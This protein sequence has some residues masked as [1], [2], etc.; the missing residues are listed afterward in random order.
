MAWIFDYDITCWSL[1]AIYRVCAHHRVSIGCPC[2]LKSKKLKFVSPHVQFNNILHFCFLFFGH[3]GL[4]FR[5]WHYILSQYPLLDPHGDADAD[6]IHFWMIWK[7][8]VWPCVPHYCGWRQLLL[9]VVYAVRQCV[10][11][12]AQRAPVFLV[13]AATCRW[14]TRAS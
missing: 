8:H 3:H 11:S 10:T 9:V 12:V 5:L 2:E 4:N 6:Y 1:F 13:C 14:I 7:K